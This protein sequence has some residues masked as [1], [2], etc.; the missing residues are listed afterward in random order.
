M[1][2]ILKNLELV[3]DKEK[4][5]FAYSGNKYLH[6]SYVD[7]WA[8]DSNS[9]ISLMGK[10]IREKTFKVLEFFTLWRI[11]EISA[12]WPCLNRSKKAIFDNWSFFWPLSTRYFFSGWL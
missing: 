1:G 4:Q 10:S 6:L 2:N 12:E 7:I 8:E 11:F 3:K 9:V 5:K